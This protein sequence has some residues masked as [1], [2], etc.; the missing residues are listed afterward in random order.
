MK[1]I[2]RLYPEVKVLG[3][4]FVGVKRVTV[5]NQSLSLRDILQRF[6][7]RESL[8]VLQEG[9][10]EDRFGDLEK[11]KEEDITQKHER[12]NELKDVVSKGRK[13][14]KEAAEKAKADKKKADAEAF[15]EL[16]NKLRAAPV[17]TGGGKNEAGPPG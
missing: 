13:A 7:R 11:I 8:P 9:F 2:L 5:P 10:Y 1:K 12:V 17:S 16:S 15:E 6:V 3:Q 4:S 14:E